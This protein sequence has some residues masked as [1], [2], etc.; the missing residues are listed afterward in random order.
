MNGQSSGASSISGR[1]LPLIEQVEVFMG[2][3][4]QLSKAWK[5]G[6]LTNEEYRAAKARLLGLAVEPDY[7]VW[8]PA[9]AFI[10]LD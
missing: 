3:L 9:D 5:D 10:P 1:S 2:A 8:P 4:N 6:E 7:P